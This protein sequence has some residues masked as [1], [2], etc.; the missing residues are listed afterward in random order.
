MALRGGL[1]RSVNVIIGAAVILRCSLDLYRAYAHSAGGGREALIDSS[2]FFLGAAAAL[3]AYVMNRRALSELYDKLNGK[4]FFSSQ[5]AL[6]N[7]RQGKNA[8][9]YFYF[10]AS[11]GT[12]LA[13]ILRSEPLMGAEE[14]FVFGGYLTAHVL[15]FVFP[16]RP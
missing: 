5:L 3:P 8:V 4:V 6:L 16:P 11:A 13:N 12:Y 14:F 1:N 10:V 9:A 2:A 7:S 15:P